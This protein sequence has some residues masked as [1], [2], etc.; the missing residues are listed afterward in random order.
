MRSDIYRFLRRAKRYAREHWQVLFVWG[1]GGCFVFGGLL[2]LWAASLRIPDLS[3]LE[4]RKV[5]QSIKIYDKTGSVLLSDLNQDFARTVVPLEAI[6]QSAREAIIAIEDPGFYQHGGIAPKAILRAIVAD[7][8]P[9]GNTQGGSTITQQVVKNTILTNDKSIARKLKEWI[10]AIKVERV[11]SKDQILELYLNQIPMGGNMYGIEEAS[12]TFFG[13]HASDIS[14]LEAAYLAAVLPAPTRLSPYRLT[15]GSTRNESL[16]ARKNLVL[17]KMH[18]HGY[19]TAAERDEAK[20]AVLAFQPKRQTSIQAPHFVFYIEQYLENKY[21]QGVIEEGGWKVTTTL[22]ADLQAKAEEIVGAGALLNTTKFNASNAALVALDP[23]T[24]GIL[25]MVGSRNY[26]DTEIPGAYNVAVMRPGRQPGSTF[27]PFAYAE[28]FMKGYT[29]DTV[30]FDVPTQFSTSCSWSDPTNGGACFAPGN[31]DNTYRGPIS[32]RNALAQSI[33]IPSV[34]VLYLA[35]LADTLRLAKTMGITTLADPARY[36]LTLVLG[37]G[38]VT[39]LDITSAYGVFATDGVRYEPNAI[40]KIEDSSGNVIEDN[41]RPIGSQVLPRDVTQKI[42]DVLSDNAAR[43]PLGVNSS[44]SFPGRE[45][46]V[47]TGTT[48]NYRDAWTIGYTPSFVLGMWAG[49]NDNTEMQKKVSGLIVGPMWHDVMAYQLPKLPDE[50]FSRA[51]FTPPQKPSLAGNWLV[52]GDDGQIH[53]I[54]YWVDRS[55]PTG[56]QPSNA[57][58]DSQYTRWEL[59][60]QNWLSQSGITP[61][62]VEESDPDRRRNNDDEEEEENNNN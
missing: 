59:P 60:V 23:N 42:N 21:G 8:I 10:L 33:N 28:A 45:V 12:E 14:V 58:N 16:E 29:P 17:Q 53:E 62:P 46:A 15:E 18:E 34:K 20:A 31:Y 32:L 47:K 41:W 44:L 40:L 35:G 37:G 6:S 38:E 4:S 43:E 36:G 2:F 48:N 52:P 57:G 22:D 1:V 27:K 24:G 13:K 26:F 39:L 9:G 7:V 55:D 51:E 5:E 25:A 19:L 54:L 30:V 11:L 49:N 61:Q 3:S 50:S 56:P